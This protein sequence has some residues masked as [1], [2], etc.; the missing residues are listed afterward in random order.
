MK[1]FVYSKEKEKLMHKAKEDMSSG[2]KET[3]KVG[4]SRNFFESII[5]EEIV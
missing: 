5:N 1:Q 2:G 4:N 3:W